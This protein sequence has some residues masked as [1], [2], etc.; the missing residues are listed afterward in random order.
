MD[1]VKD[2]IKSYGKLTED[3]IVYFNSKDTRII[4]S[5]IKDSL[6][7]D[8]MYQMMI[9]KTNP[10]FILEIK[11]NKYEAEYLLESAK[12]K[13][14]YNYGDFETVLLLDYKLSGHPLIYNPEPVVE[15]KNNFCPDQRR[16]DFPGGEEAWLKYLQDNLDFYAPKKNKAPAGTYKVEVKF[17]IMQDGSIGEIVVSGLT[18]KDYGIIKEVNRVLSAAPKW[19]PAMQCGYKKYPMKQVFNFISE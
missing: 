16:A 6:K 9:G 12:E 2:L 13:A 1:V 17:M 3:D 14:K 10:D 15:E 4:R 7:N 19:Y 18:G 11:D 8:F 5:M